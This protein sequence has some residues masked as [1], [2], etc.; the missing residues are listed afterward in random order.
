MDD[1]QT[2]HYKGRNLRLVYDDG[3]RV[4]VF[5]NDKEIY[6]TSAKFEHRD[7]A[8]RSAK[9]LVDVELDGRMVTPPT[10]DRLG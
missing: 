1:V 6:S 8:I 7:D 4:V 5:H 2:I 9:D 3:F 10:G